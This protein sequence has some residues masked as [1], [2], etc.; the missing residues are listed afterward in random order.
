MAD[1]GR[2]MTNRQR[3]AEAESKHVDEAQPTEA[4]T[5]MSTAVVR[6]KPKPNDKSEDEFIRMMFEN[7]VK[8]PYMRSHASLVPMVST[9]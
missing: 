5:E 3:A 2:R 1:G 6:S 4:E 8:D 7:D 9:F